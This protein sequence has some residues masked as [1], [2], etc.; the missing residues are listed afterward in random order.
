MV[1]GP[2]RF[3]PRVEVVIL[4]T[5]RIIPLDKNEG[6]YLRNF[7]TGQVYTHIG[8]SYALKPNEILWEKDLPENIES[9]YIRDLNL[10]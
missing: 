7:K 1:N 6:I 3:I 10:Y 2:K 9:I 5:R 8:S 4:E